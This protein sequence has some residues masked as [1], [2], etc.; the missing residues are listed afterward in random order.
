MICNRHITL[1][2]ILGEIN[3]FRNINLEKISLLKDFFVTG[4]L[5]LKDE[6]KNPFQMKTSQFIM[7]CRRMYAHFRI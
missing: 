1:K 4:A 7:Y 5:L 2:L 3:D 6:L